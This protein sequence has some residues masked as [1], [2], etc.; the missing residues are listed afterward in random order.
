MRVRWS[1]L[2]LCG[3]PEHC[4]LD[5]S[6]HGCIAVT[7][8]CEQGGIRSLTEQVTVASAAGF[9]KKAVGRRLIADLWTTNRQDA[10]L[11]DSFTQKI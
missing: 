2:A 1:L 8:R 4:D 6:Q 5:V 7:R 10:R 3:C 11:A 9:K